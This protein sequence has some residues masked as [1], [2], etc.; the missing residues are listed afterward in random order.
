MGLLWFYDEHDDVLLQIEEEFRVIYPPVPVTVKKKKT[1]R[2]SKIKESKEIKKTEEV[3]PTT[4]SV[5][6]EERKDAQVTN[7]A[8]TSRRQI[9]KKKETNKEL[10]QREKSTPL[11]S[12]IQPTKKSS[13]GQSRLR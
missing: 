2:N 9:P 10:S 13:H 8:L 12:P 7:K 6:K 4:T 5:I 11:L 1:K 3:K